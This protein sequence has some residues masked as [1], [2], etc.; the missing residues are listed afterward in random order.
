MTIPLGLMFTTFVLGLRHG[1][2]W[3]HIAA[4][5]DIAGTQET[6]QRGLW[7][8]TVYALGHASVVL[9]L[10]VLAIGFAERLPARV[11]ATMERVVG[12][13]LVLLG[14]YVLVALARNRRDFRMRS[15]WMVVFEAARR[16]TRWVRSQLRRPD[17]E[18]VH[19]HTHPVGDHHGG[20]AIRTDAAAQRPSIATR[21][22]HRH[23]HR[24]AAP[25]PEDPFMNYSTVTAFGI[26]M[27]HG[28]G[29]ETP[30]Q[31]LIFLTAAGV[32][33]V[34][35]G[36]VL[37]VVFLAGLLASNT[38]IA[39]ASSFGFLRAGR[40]FA[41]YAVVSAVAG[42]LSLAVGGLLLLGRGGML[43]AILGS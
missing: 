14:V 5:T 20:A 26:G 29:A 19:D 3:D 38:A 2:D 18:I 41:V 34:T 32:G 31:V 6:G 10:G 35:S 15:R 22:A 28:V 4:I 43:P 30:T 27:I 17:I 36:M 37:L 12:A 1:I 42:L 16:V 40:N 21:T 39:V 7:L 24:H 33:G 11:D 13:T 8:S 23:T 25:L 9:V